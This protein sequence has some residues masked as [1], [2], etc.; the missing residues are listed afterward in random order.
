M[1]FRVN[2]RL[3]LHTIL[4]CHCSWAHLSLTACIRSTFSF[5]N[6]SPGKDLP[7]RSVPPVHSFNWKWKI[8]SS[9]LN[10][11]IH[12]FFIYEFLSLNLN[13]EKRRKKTKKNMALLLIILSCNFMSIQTF[14]FFFDYP[15]MNV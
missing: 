12:I 8:E 15:E 5:W 13:K 3:F 7:Q 2:T 11:G 9:T 6:S 10:Y 14:F 4:W 1:E